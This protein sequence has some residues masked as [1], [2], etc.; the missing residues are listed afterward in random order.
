MQLIASQKLLTLDTVGTSTPLGDDTG[1][2]A[3]NT[4]VTVRFSAGTTAGTYVVEVADDVAFAGTWAL[5]GTITWA[6]ANSIKTAL[7]TGPWKAL[8]VRNTVAVANGS[9]EVTIQV[10]G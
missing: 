6:V 2:K 7:V 10:N 3:A 9:A 1:G 8:R 5:L 4:M